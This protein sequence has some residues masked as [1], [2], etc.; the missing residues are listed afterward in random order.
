M[1]HLNALQRMS[2]PQFVGYL[3]GVGALSGV[4]AW[5]LVLTG[6]FVFDVDRPTWL[7]LVLAIPRGSLFA[8]ILGFGLRLWWRVRGDKSGERHDP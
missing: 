6:A 2:V 4:G 8:L 5:C 1:T 3:V 7:A